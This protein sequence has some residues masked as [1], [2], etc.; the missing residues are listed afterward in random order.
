VVYVEGELVSTGDGATG[1]AFHVG[2]GWLLTGAHVITDLRQPRIWLE[3]P[4]DRRDDLAVPITSRI[5]LRPDCDLAL[6]PTAFAGPVVPFITSQHPRPRRQDEVVILGYPPIAGFNEPT[7][8]SDRT[9]ISA[10]PSRPDRYGVLSFVM[11]L[12]DRPGFSGGPVVLQTGVACGVISVARIL[13]GQTG[14]LTEFTSAVSYQ[15]V[16]DLLLDAWPE[17]EGEHATWIREALARGITAH[18]GFD[19]A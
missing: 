18:Q 1:T 2:G 8:V 3:H 16:W 10:Y 11:S 17:E 14:V 19:D 9:Y 15:H 13:D 5:L 7:L 6:I 12:R 4:G